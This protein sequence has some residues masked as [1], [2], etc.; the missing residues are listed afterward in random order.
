[1]DN[2]SRSERTRNLV[3]EAARVI[4]ARD[5]PQRLTLDA[6]ARE[7]GISKGGLMHQFG[8]KVAVIRALLENQIEYF[9]KFSQNHIATHGAN[10]AEPHLAAQI[11]VAREAISQTQPSS[12]AFAILGM[13]GEAPELMS[14][15]RDIDVKGAE[16]IKAE[17]AD[18]DLAMLRLFAAQGMHLTTVFGIGRLSV[19]D[20]ERLFARLADSSQWTS[21]VAKKT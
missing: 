9:E 7:A 15:F 3:I 21:P 4:I 10:S 17:A 18:P 2:T 12:V 1:M 11:A 8:N 16:A 14:V 20:R 13:I 5:G 6:I 19:E